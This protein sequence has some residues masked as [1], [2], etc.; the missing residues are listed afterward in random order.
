M[1]AT[2]SA[3]STL[4]RVTLGP[5]VLCGVMAAQT[6]P[7][8]MRRVEPTVQAWLSRQV[9]GAFEAWV[10]GDPEGTLDPEAH[11]IQLTPESR[12]AL[13][14]AMSVDRL[15]LAVLGKSCLQADLW[16]AHVVAVCDLDEVERGVKTGRFAGVLIEAGAIQLADDDRLQRLSDRVPVAGYGVGEAV[17]LD[18]IRCVP[19]GRTKSVKPTEDGSAALDRF[20]FQVGMDTLLSHL[21]RRSARWLLSSRHHW[22]RTT[23]TLM[24]DLV[25]EGEEKL[26]HSPS[27]ADAVPFSEIPTTRFADIIGMGAVKQTLMAAVQAHV[28][29]RPGDPTPPKGYLLAGPPGC[30]KTLLAQALA[31]EAG[32][33]FL[34]LAAGSLHDMYVG[35]TERKIREL[36][37]TARRHRPA[38]IFLDEVDA[39]AM[40]RQKASLTN[41][42]YVTSILTTLLDC[43]DGFTRGAAP[44]LVLAATNH[45]QTLDPAFVRAG[46][47][48]QIITLTLP[49]ARDR[50]AFL[51]THLPDEGLDADHLREAV[52][53]T[54]GMAFSDLA[55][56][57]KDLKAQPQGAAPVGHLRERLLTHF[58]GPIN[59]DLRMDE[60]ARHAV[61]IH[62][63]GHAVVRMALRQEAPV[64]LSIR[65]RM[66]GSL[67]VTVSLP[68][69]QAVHMDASWVLDEMAICLAGRAAEMLFL[70]TRAPGA[71]ASDDLERATSLALKAIGLYGLE[72]A[73]GCMSM[74]VLPPEARGAL[75]VDLAAHL[76]DWLGK[77]NAKAEAALQRNQAVVEGLAGALMVRPE[78]FGE[79]LDGLLE[80]T[81]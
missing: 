64:Y 22:D 51:R 73:W 65:P 47:F 28:A 43:M 27:S 67:G 62:E 10:T 16:G 75:G 5:G 66:K 77:A 4:P 36:F 11:H 40:D 60:A 24:T 53:F 37:A 15:H 17:P 74:G 21:Q 68:D 25:Y 19:K 12:A 6:P 30:G 48:D 80:G 3:T 81:T 32:L 7:H 18:A 34:A 55:Q 13:M 59:P 70:P 42:G 69:H 35:E 38:I 41:P 72:P 26:L 56:A 2:V 57:I 61:A 50:E 71:G 39:L 33:P 14:N 58:L 31:G 1:N 44:V 46:R 9:L 78:L 52:R 8:D 79:E 54:E 49:T 20:L 63:A 29:W 45:P 76:K 23:R